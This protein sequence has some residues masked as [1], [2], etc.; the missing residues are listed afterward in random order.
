[1]VIKHPSLKQKKGENAMRSYR[2]NALMS[3]L[4]VGLFILGLW[5]CAT[6]KKTIP[7]AKVQ[8]IP[9]K[10]FLSPAL[11]KKPVQFKGSGFVPKEMVFVDMVLPE[12][13]K[14]KGVTGGE[15]VGIAYATADQKGNFQAA[16]RP[17]ATLNWFFQV[18]WTSN[19]KPD[20]KQAKP[21]PPGK[22]EIRATGMDSQVF[23]KTAFY[24]ILPPKKK[25]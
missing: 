18:G 13:V 25:K 14:V 23:G 6:T 11:I 22:Y 17:T 1:M 5:G 2:F 12:G 8:V 24:I 10:F 16:M 7:T 19:M 15:D 3:F 9:E 4:F 21:L 20:F